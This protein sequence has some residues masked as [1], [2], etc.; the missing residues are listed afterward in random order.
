MTPDE[1][2]HAVP[3]HVSNSR[4]L[5]RRRDAGRDDRGPA[6]G[7]ALQQPR[8]HIA[9]LHVPPQEVERS[10]AV[11]VP[12]ARELPGQRYGSRQRRLKQLTG[13][14]HLS[15]AD[16]AG[17]YVPPDQW[18]AIRLSDVQANDDPRALRQPDIAV[19]PRGQVR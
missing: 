6:D 16:I 11:Q 17:V 15:D 18:D 1:V 19:R 5:P 7:A 3:V 2:G 9:C 12:N 14:S 4:N 8:G 10:V 13:A